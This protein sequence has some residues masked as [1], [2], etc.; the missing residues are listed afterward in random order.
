MYF[1]IG[2]TNLLNEFLATLYSAVTGTAV[3]SKQK[4]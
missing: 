1:T 4:V 2:F 3:K